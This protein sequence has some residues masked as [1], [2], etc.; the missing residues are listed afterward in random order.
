M[1][2]SI[3]TPERSMLRGVQPGRAVC[4]RGRRGTAGLATVRRVGRWVAFECVGLRAGWECVAG[5]GTEL[6][7]EAA[8]VEP[9]VPHAVITS[10]E[11][12]TA[13]TTLTGPRRDPTRNR[14]N[15][16]AIRHIDA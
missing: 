6:A 9:T 4:V 11:L 8:C 2:R 5:G 15:R 14:T 10:N 3:A 13:L 1:R 12:N 7:A 16:R